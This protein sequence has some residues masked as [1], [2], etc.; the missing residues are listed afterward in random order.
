M[1]GFTRNR[2]V[3]RIWDH[4]LKAST[5]PRPNT[6]NTRIINPTL[7]V[8]LHLLWIA[9]KGRDRGDGGENSRESALSSPL[10]FPSANFQATI[11]GITRRASAPVCSGTRQSFISCITTGVR[12]MGSQMRV[13]LLHG[14]SWQR[15]ETSAL[16]RWVLQLPVW[17][18]RAGK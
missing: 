4:F 12:D 6:V 8:W 1:D 3:P 11:C 7:L 9:G 15:R 5:I 13:K 16:F 14:G 2:K 18:W 10:S 17:L